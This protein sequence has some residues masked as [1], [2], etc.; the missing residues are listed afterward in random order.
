MAYE[1]RY[2]ALELPGRSQ[3]RFGVELPPELLAR[4]ELEVTFDGFD[5]ALAISSVQLRV[6]RR[7][8][9]SSTLSQKGSLIRAW[10]DLAGVSDVAFHAI[11]LGAAVL[12]RLHT[13]EAC[14]R[15]VFVAVGEF[16]DGFILQVDDD[17]SA[18]PVSG[19]RPRGSPNADGA[20]AELE[21]CA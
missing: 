11:T 8:I 6:G 7:L 5:D 16:E 17:G 4:D 15:F 19:P 9:N 1:E 14:R 3:V 18:I 10:F 20:L 13:G 21:I 12:A 2:Q